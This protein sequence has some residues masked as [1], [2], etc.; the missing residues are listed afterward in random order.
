MQSTIDNR[1]SSIQPR[2][3]L[4]VE[5]FYGGSHRAF[6]DGLVRHSRHEFTLL[7]LPEG[8]WRRRMRRGAQELAGLASAVTGEFDLL[9]VT[10][11]LDLPVFLALTRPRF[12][13]TPVLAYFHENQFT[14]PRIRGTKFNSWFGQ[15]N[16]LTALSADTVAF[17]SAF[18][19]DDFLGALGTLASQPNNWL[20][21]SAIVEIAAK[22]AI[23]PIGVELDWLDRIAA[24][25]EPSE[26]PVILWNHRWEFDKSPELFAR[27]VQRLAEEGVPFR[28][29]IAGEPGLNP[30]PALQDLTEALPERVLHCGFVES[31]EAYGHLL[32]QSSVAVSTTRHEFFGVAMVEAMYAGCLPLAPQRYNYPALVPPALHG[33]CLFETEDEFVAKL[34]RLLLDPAQARSEVTASAARFAWPTVIRQWDE[35]IERVSSR[36]FATREQPEPSKR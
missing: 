18:H 25:R 3:V 24:E 4:F 33:A 31:R 30:T 12:A 32:K 19:R 27:G 36:D 1:Q 6:L 20:V 16:Y 10:D 26:P 34:R 13:Q 9:I 17:N 29:A 35:A 8:E 2:R 11:M 14:Y 28:L 21:E 7:T 23:L 22:S 5:P 15:L